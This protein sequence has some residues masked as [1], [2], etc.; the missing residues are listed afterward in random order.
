M[1]TMNH[2][3]IA[4]AVTLC[5]LAQTAL[6]KAIRLIDEAVTELAPEL[7]FGNDPATTDGAALERFGKELADYQKALLHADLYAPHCGEA[8]TALKNVIRAR[9]AEAGMTSAGKKGLSPMKTIAAE[10]LSAAIR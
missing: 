7:K 3:R 8:I 5:E 4:S 9:R 6:W 2:Q 10:N 1:I